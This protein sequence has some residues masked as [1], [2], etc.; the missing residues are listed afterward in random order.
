MRQK[1][2]QTTT[3]LIETESNQR[4]LDTKA[5]MYRYDDGRRLHLPPHMP[6]PAVSVIRSSHAFWLLLFLCSTSR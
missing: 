5:V 4:S 3:L 1:E 6:A 2:A